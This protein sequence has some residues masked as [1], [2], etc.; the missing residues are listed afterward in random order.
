MSAAIFDALRCRLSPTPFDVA[1]LRRTLMSIESS[2]EILELSLPQCPWP[3]RCVS[4]HFDV[5]A[6]LHDPHDF[7][8]RP[9]AFPLRLHCFAEEVLRRQCSITN[10]NNNNNKE[11]VRRQCSITAAM[12][13]DVSQQ[14]LT[15]TTMKSH[16]NRAHQPGRCSTTTALLHSTSPPLH[17]HFTSTSPP[18][19]S[20]S[21][22][23][24]TCT[25]HMFVTSDRTLESGH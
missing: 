23:S 15:A 16:N 22:H 14:L 10:N 25:S 21:L 9:P 18:L 17:L 2:T 20:F 6:L 5:V 4:M 19:R 13:H 3:S 24:H 7:P 12:L 8:L 1:Y 11:V